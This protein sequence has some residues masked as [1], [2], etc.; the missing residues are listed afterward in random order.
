MTTV[1]KNADNL[2]TT[3]KQTDWKSEIES[4]TKTLKDETVVAIKTVEHLPEHVHH[5]LSYHYLHIHNFKNIG[6][7]YVT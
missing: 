5:L 4:F 1:K 3:A 6:K 7:C 2:V